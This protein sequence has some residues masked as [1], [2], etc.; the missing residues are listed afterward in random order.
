MFVGLNGDSG[1]AVVRAL[2]TSKMWVYI[3][4][5]PVFWGICF[6]WQRQSN[7]IIIT[8]E[9][10]LILSGLAASNEGDAYG[11]LFTASP[12]GLNFKKN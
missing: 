7:S 10:A 6:P 9:I 11:L 1:G 12:L 2:P 8:A 4:L 3:W 5:M